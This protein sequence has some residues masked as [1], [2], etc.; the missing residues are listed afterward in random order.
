MVF[1]LLFFKKSF[2]GVFNLFASGTCISLFHYFLSF[3]LLTL[4]LFKVVF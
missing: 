3:I 2:Y 4:R 1:F